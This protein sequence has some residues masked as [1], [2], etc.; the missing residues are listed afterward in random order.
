VSKTYNVTIA[1]LAG[2]A[3]FTIDVVAL[4][5]AGGSITGVGIYSDGDP[6]TL[7]AIPNAGYF[8]VDWTEGGAHFAFTKIYSFTAVGNRNLVANFLADNGAPTTSAAL[9]GALGGGGWYVGNVDITLTAGDD[10]SGVN[11]TFYK[12]DGGA[13]QSYAGPF[14]IASSGS[15]T[16]EFWSDD[17]AGNTE[18]AQSQAVKIDVAAPGVSISSD[19]PKIWPANGKL[20]TVTISGTVTDNASGPDVGS[21]TYSTVDSYGQLEP[22]GVFT[23]A[24][25]GTYSF[26]IQIDSTRNKKDPA[27]RT[28]TITVNAAD[29]AGYGTSNA[30]V[31]LVPLR[32]N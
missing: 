27:G 8:F 30:T 4:P 21:G 10:L 28:Y 7:E 24:P 1:G 26:T 19:P 14:T 32:K 17:V 15:H 20:V 12:I 6:V 31:V 18:A 13:T 9:S 29:V 16:I 5:V 11:Q 23:I 25:N 3:S 22:S 2:P